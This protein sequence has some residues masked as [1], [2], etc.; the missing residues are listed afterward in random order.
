M[1]AQQ[2][3]GLV[4]DR[5]VVIVP[6]KTVAQGIS[7]I[8]AYNPDSSVSGNM[9][10][11]TEAASKVK[12]GQITFAARDSEFGGFKISE[13]EILALSDGKLVLTEKNPIEAVKKLVS[14]M[15][16]KETEFIT[17]IYGDSITEEKAEEAKK[18]IEGSLKREIEINL[19]KGD[20]PIYHF[21]VSVE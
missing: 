18:A 12:T 13:G 3:V 17:L 9:E 4:K 20:Q 8:L 14:M 2:A 5:T 6:T 19:I 16:S 21:I 10:I 11:M 1:S 7:A 15:V